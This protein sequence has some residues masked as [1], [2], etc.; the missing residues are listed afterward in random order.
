[1]E[2]VEINL[3][4]IKNLVFKEKLFISFFTNSKVI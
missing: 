2:I 4:C 1:M 3:Y